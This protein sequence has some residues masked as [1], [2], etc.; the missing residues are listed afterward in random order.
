M[1]T[2]RAIDDDNKVQMEYYSA[3]KGIKNIICSNMN[4]PRNYHTK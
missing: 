4:G 3:I 1:S 2:D